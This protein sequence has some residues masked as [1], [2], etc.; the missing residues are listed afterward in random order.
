MLVWPLTRRH[1]EMRIA[2]RRYAPLPDADVE[3]AGPTLPMVM[4]QGATPKGPKKSRNA[5]TATGFLSTIVGALTLFA[6]KAAP[7]TPMLLGVATVGVTVHGVNSI[8]KDISAIERTINQASVS[9]D[10]VTSSPVVSRSGE[11][12][13]YIA[14]GL[15]STVALLKQIENSK[16]VE[17][18]AG[19]D[20]AQISRLMEKLSDSDLDKFIHSLG[21]L[22]DSLDRIKIHN[23][24][25]I[26]THSGSKMDYDGSIL[27]NHS[28]EVL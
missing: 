24:V 20:F 21:H 4:P 3:E 11:Y 6:S 8:T 5:K 9:I 26:S 23:D 2:Q 13:G 25:S 10:S 15:Q 28:S 1:L 22:I 12:A 7:V 27:R 14:P 18:V 16:V 19:M 17:R